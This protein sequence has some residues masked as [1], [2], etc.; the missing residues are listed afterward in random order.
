MNWG[1]LITALEASGLT[2]NEIAKEVGCSQGYVS[3]L[4][5]GARTNPPFDL[6][7]GLERLHEQRCPQERVA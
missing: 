2:Q 3:Q 1:A 6:G 4:K 7:R 5:T